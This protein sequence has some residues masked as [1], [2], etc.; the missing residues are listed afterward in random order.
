MRHSLLSLA[1]LLLAATAA[2]A[3]PVDDYVRDVMAGKKIPGVSIAILRG[4]AVVK[5]Q[6]YGM[7][8]LELDT[9]ATP[10]TIYQSGSLGK[11]FTAAGILL[12]AEDG[13]LALDDRLAKHFP[14]GPST[15]HRITIRHL[16]THTSGLKD[17]GSDEIDFRRD[18][19]EDDLLKVAR[20]IPLEFEPGTQ[21][22]Y[23]NTG[24]LILGLLTSRLAGKH[25]SDFQAQ[26]IF[27][28]LGM[29]TTRIIS[30]R[31]IVR[32]RA[33]GYELD[34]KGE[35]K[36]QD[37]VAPSLNRL[38]DGALYFSVKDLAAWEAALH[39]R[40][41]M[42]PDSFEAWW[43]PAS[44]GGRLTYP[45]GFGWGMGE[46]RGHRLI[47]H[48]GSWQGFRTAIARYVDQ[49]LTIIVL[50]NLAQAQPETMAHEIAGLVEPGLKRPDPSR[51]APDPDAARTARLRD[52]LDAW[53][54]YRRTPA[55]AEGLASTETGSR[56]EASQRRTTGRRLAEM[57]AF[58]YLGE[59]DLSARPLTIRGD[60]VERT[61]YYALDSKDA[62]HVYRF[63]L[64]RDGRVVDFD[65][66]ER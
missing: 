31:D 27:Q 13:K 3:D 44:L 37:W 39:A 38:A 17:Y 53:A 50:A 24:Y 7:A 49:G 22:S 32:N 64:A 55:L 29:A 34:D 8:N 42:R 33:A 26:R 2:V 28:P 20:T 6:G 48:G 46:Q 66:E 1:V 14:E 40:R 63:H 47:E 30:E 10:D 56:R 25:W 4:G 12:L 51:A 35:V 11:Q 23:S 62:R 41:F 43:T 59:D 15:W 58:R 54:N 60:S 21:W 65:S 19:S 16:L 5:V 57:T 45:Y 52:V 36:N 61:V 18:Y 9:P